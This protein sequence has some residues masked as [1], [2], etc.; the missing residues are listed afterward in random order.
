[1]SDL[2]FYAKNG[3]VNLILRGVALPSPTTLYMRLFNTNPGDGGT[4]DEITGGGYG[5]VA[6]TMGTDTNGVGTNSAKI[7]YAT[8][9]SDWDEINYLAV[10]DH[11]TAGNLLAHSTVTQK[12]IT[13]GNN[14]SFAI[15]AFSIS[16]TVAPWSNY[17][18]SAI[19]K[20]FF[21][22]TAYTPTTIYAAAYKTDP[23]PEDTGTEASTYTRQIVTYI[24]PDD[25]VTDNSIQVTFNEG[26]INNGTIT[27]GALKDAITDGN[28]L[29]SSVLTDEIVYNI[30]D[31]PRMPIN[32]N[33]IT[34]A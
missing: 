26:T 7:N 20:H 29:M 33:I 21:K 24:A 3:S 27:H 15:G 10:F 4:G 12:T 28:L 34:V 5:A 9:T 25:G 23:T 18:R 19:Y 30:G 11:P 13:T 22:A 17:L 32:T 2:S 14:C 6:F 8:A 31:T 1:M 16:V